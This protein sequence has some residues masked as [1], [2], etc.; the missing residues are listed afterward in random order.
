MTVAADW[1]R[2][3]RNWASECVDVLTEAADALSIDSEPTARATNMRRCGHR[4]SAL[5]DRGRL[6]LPNE[7]HDEYGVHKLPAFRGYRPVALDALEASARVLKGTADLY[8]FSSAS[9]AI[10]SLRKEFVSTIQGILDPRSS[11]AKIASML[12]RAYERTRDQKL[13][14]LIPDPENI[15]RGA[16]R[17]LHSASMRFQRDQGLETL[18]PSPRQKT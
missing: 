2:D 3:V 5:I 16:T 10:Q 14:G 6:L 11:N 9:E 13:G 8:A 7:V 18:R 4:L 12:V 15:P 17:L 1:I